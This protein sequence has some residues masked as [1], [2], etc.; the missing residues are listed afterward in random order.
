MTRYILAFML[1]IL[2]A[3]CCD[4][5][6]V[7]WEEDNLVSM[8]LWALVSTLLITFASALVFRDIQ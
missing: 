8:F 6:H 7:Q 3:L 1:V 5:I 4:I 2:F